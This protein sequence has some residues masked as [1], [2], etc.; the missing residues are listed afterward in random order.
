MRRST[1]RIL[2]T[3][4]GSLPP[5][6]LPQPEPSDETTRMRAQV[7]AVVAHQREAGLDILNEG[8][9]TKGGTW[10]GYVDGRFN[11]L[12]ARDRISGPPLMRQGK[13]REAFADFY[14]YAANS[15]ALTYTKTPYPTKTGSANWV[16][17][18][19]ITYVGQAAV[20]R[21]IDLLKEQVAPQDGF[22]TTVAP[23]SLEVHCENEGF[24]DPDAMVAAIAGAMATEYEM[25]ADAGF[26]VQVDDAWTAALWDRIGV[27]MGLQKFREYCAKRIDLLN[28]ALARVPEEKI[29]YHLCWGSWHG[30]HAFDIEMR[31][32]V[33]LML[34]VKAGSYSFEAAN[35]R[36]EHEYVVWDDVKLPQG[37]VMQPGVISHASNV[38]EHP[39]LVSQ[40]IQ[41]FA[42]RVGRENVVASADCGFGGRTHPQIA[43]AKLTA[44]TEGAR[45]ASRQL[46]PS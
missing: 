4:V 43:W 3:H 37:K 20:Q 30:P 7:E 21:S 18:G 38:I 42:A 28:K 31:D 15:G 34:R 35:P 6:A 16:C 17:T 25:I 11:G 36:H 33:D 23:A 39:E 2:T 29:R 19:P 27:Q 44:L 10:I 5:P 9:V 8:E 24:E 13:D 26:D 14:D 41:R 32:M 22:I 46:W 12:V 1:D 40:R 45:L